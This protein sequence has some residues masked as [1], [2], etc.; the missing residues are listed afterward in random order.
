MAVRKNEGQT[1]KLKLLNGDRAFRASELLA[2]GREPVCGEG[3][4]KTWSCLLS[5]STLYLSWILRPTEC[6]PQTNNAST[7]HSFNI[8]L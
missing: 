6:D 5:K 1:I 8:N 7:I 3:F 4:L 2:E